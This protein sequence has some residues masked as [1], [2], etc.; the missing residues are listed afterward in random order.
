[1]RSYM[2]SKPLWL[3]CALLN[4]T[5]WTQHWHKGKRGSWIF[6]EN[7]Q[8]SYYLLDLFNCMK[9]LNF[10]GVF[11]INFLVSWTNWFE[12][13]INYH[14]LFYFLLT[15]PLF[16]ESIICIIRVIDYQVTEFTCSIIFC[17]NIQ[18]SFGINR[19]KNFSLLSKTFS[20]IFFLRY[21]SWILVQKDWET[22]FL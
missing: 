4:N 16:I 11:G 21:Y 10:I 20:C 5:R 22:C 18:F 7:T 3:F 13:L 2:S 14:N 1:M 8:P 12:S 9:E 6:W 17:W 19:Y 15:H